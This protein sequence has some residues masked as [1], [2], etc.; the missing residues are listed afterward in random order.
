MKAL[1]SRA[2]EKRLELAA[3]QPDVPRQL[4]G[5]PGRLRQIVVNLA[6]N[7]IKFTDKGEVVIGVEE[8]RTPPKRW[9]SCTSASPI[10]GSGYHGKTTG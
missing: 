2:H 7:A 10:P 4:V 5:D 9:K 6:G 8:V 3:D 1:A